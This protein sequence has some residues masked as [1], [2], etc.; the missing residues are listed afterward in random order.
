MD[1][2]LTGEYRIEEWLGDVILRF[3]RS[4]HLSSEQKQQYYDCVQKLLAEIRKVQ[5]G[6]PVLEVNREHAAVLNDLRVALSSD[7][8]EDAVKIVDELERSLSK[9]DQTQDPL[10]NIVRLYTRMYQR[11]PFTFIILLVIV[12]VF[13]VFIFMK[14]IL[15]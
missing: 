9:R 3:E 8:V 12:I 11:S 6:K 15:K 1:I 7:K 5:E 4:R 2:D 13:Y 10:L 14:F